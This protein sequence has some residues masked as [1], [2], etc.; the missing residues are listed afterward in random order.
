MFGFATNFDKKVLSL[1][2]VMLKAWPLGYSPIY[3]EFA[4]SVW[5]FTPIKMLQT[6]LSL[7][8][9]YGRIK[10]KS[11]IVGIEALVSPH[12]TQLFPLQNSSCCLWN[13]QEGSLW[14]T[15]F[16]PGLLLILG[17]DR[18]AWEMISHCSTHLFTCALPWPHIQCCDAPALPS[19][20]LFCVASRRKRWYYQ[21]LSCPRF[22]HLL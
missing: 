6:S 5:L 2:G 13:N 14:F 22:L 3:S 4:F 12:Q 9:T 21:H 1:A 16:F 15:L 20:G 18:E 19:Q 10:G 8:G 17:K 11:C 7:M